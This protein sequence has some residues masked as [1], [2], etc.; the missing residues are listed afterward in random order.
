VDPARAVQALASLLSNAAKFSPPGSTIEVGAKSDG[1]AIRVTVRD[2][3]EGIPEEFRARI[4]G[5]FAQAETGAG[6]GG[7]GLG[8][9]IA[10]ELVVQ[11]RGEIGFVSQLG[12]GSTFWIEFPVV[13][14]AVPAAALC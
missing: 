13:S 10:R 4:F 2:R 12:A 6:R 1:D 3:G 9:H 8:L 14:R 11:M 5:R 7:T